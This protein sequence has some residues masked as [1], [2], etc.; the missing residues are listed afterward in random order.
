MEIFVRCDQITETS[1]TFVVGNYSDE[2]FLSISNFVNKQDTSG[3]SKMSLHLSLDAPYVVLPVSE[4][5]EDHLLLD[6]GHL[7]I[8]N[9]LMMD[10][11]DLFDTM[12]IVVDDVKIKRYF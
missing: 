9:H 4:Q 8:D 7:K 5:S 10:K 12:D 6:L 3:F 1:T 2:N 11:E